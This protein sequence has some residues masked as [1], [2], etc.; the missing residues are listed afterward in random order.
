MRIYM[1]KIYTPDKRIET[2]KSRIQ[3]KDIHKKET[4]MEKIYAY[5]ETN[6]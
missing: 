1:E 4:F 6:I 2:Y 5:R 3:G